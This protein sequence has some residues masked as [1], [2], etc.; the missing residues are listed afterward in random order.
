MKIK[1]FIASLG[2][3]AITSLAAVTAHAEAINVD[4]LLQLVKEGQV[5]DNNE[6]NQ[7]VEKF[8]AD[9]AGQEA[10][11]AQARAERA[12]LES[13]SASKEAEF[14]SNEARLADAQDRLTTRLG[15][16]KE[17][18]G[19]LQQVSADTQSLFQDSV[20]SAEVPG[21]DA[22]LTALITKAGSTSELPSMEELEQL[23]FEMQREMTYSGRVSKFTTDVVMPSGTTE[24]KEVVRVGGFNLVADGKYLSF[25]FET[26]KVQELASQ[27][28]GRYTDAI[29]DLENASGTGLSG[30]WIDPSRGQLLRILGQSA[31]LYDRIEQG[32]TVG[33]VI[34]VL[35]IIGLLIAAVRIVA[36][37][38]ETSRVKKQIKAEVASD[39]NSLGRVMKVYNNY[40]DVDIET[41]ELHLAEAISAEIPK[42]TK[43]ISWIKIVS[44]VSPLLGL[45]GTVTGMID[46]FE[47]LSLFGS[48]D[49]KLMANGI[50]QALVTT[51]QGLVAAIP[52]VFSYTMA[53][54]RSRALIVI[55]EE[56]ATGILARKSE[57]L[58][59]AKK[60]A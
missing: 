47:T 41:L 38:F 7:R 45:L 57:E 60:A 1:S 34:I 26:Q 35:G 51:V 59:A 25:D 53:S 6:F 49:P 17:L 4:A 29:A 21:R 42:L 9:K 55:L 15:S 12:R 56:R 10:L 33:Y 58:A 46:V 30:F 19:V 52:C 37:T 39:D 31:G 3:M 50:S 14:A 32:G 27:P 13:D 8:R 36:L 40:K 2:L 28:S 24:K 23:W 20:I 11:L 44:V 48:G 5:R 16:L 18:F 22:F 54:N 43:G